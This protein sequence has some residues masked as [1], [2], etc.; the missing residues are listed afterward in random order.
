VRARG[1]QALGGRRS[2]AEP[3]TQRLT[4]RKKKVRWSFLAT[5][6][7]RRRTLVKLPDTVAPAAPERQEVFWTW[8]NGKVI[9][10]TA[11]LIEMALAENQRLALAADW[12]QRSPQRRGRRNGYYHRRLTTPYGVLSL[13]VPRARGLALDPSFV[14]ARYGRRQ[15]DVDRLLRRMFLTGTSTRDAAELAEQLWGGPLS[16]QTV[17]HLA[18]W[19][20]DHLA[21]YRRQPIQPVYPVVQ[22][23]GMYITVAGAK[24]VVML[25]VGLREDGR[26][27]VLGF[28]LGAG[29]GCADLLWDLRRR[30]LE[31]VQL[32]A[33]DDAG[34]IR[35]AIEEVYPEVPW[36][37]C[38][39]HRLVRLHDLVGRTDYRRTLVR[40]AARIFRCVSLEAALEE[41][42]RWQRRWQPYE[43]TVV[44]W[45]MDG[46]A[47]SLTFYHLPQKWWR[48]TRTT[49]R[50]ERL[51]RT[52]RM[53]LRLMGAFLNP[54]AAHRAV[55][56]QLARRHLL[57]EITHST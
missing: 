43:P 55:F 8:M 32:F 36:Q 48:R 14:F 4:W 33:S 52:L 28:S 49:S 25:V 9:Q 17:S 42:A 11:D 53:R 57:P 46:L 40:Q 16:H 19:L 54:Q 30:G 12:H 18:A 34:A 22:I 29:E 20:D 1:G 26:Q 39:W 41:A 44:R 35:A 3:P 5:N 13:R 37:S 27:E 56:G 47:D 31:G 51:I 10:L 45:F 15:A 2:A 7:E 50:T 24:Q 38:A 23:D 21:A 6:Q